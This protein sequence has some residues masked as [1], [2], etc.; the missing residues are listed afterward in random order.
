MRDV[1]R[2]TDMSFG[3]GECALHGCQAPAQTAHFASMP[4][5]FRGERFVGACAQPALGLRVCLRGSELAGEF[6]NLP[7]QRGE[8]FAFVVRCGFPGHA[9]RFVALPFGGSCH[10]ECFVGVS[11]RDIGA[12]GKLTGK[13]V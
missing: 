6:G 5:L 1:F 4:F 8:R 12:S 3:Y 7:A 2:A 13:A 11:P 9:E 10:T